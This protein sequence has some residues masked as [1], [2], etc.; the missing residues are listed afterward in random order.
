M[1]CDELTQRIAD[2]LTGDLDER[3]LTALGEHLATCPGCAAEAAALEALWHGLDDA[4]PVPSARLRPRFE[5][6]LERASENADRAIGVGEPRRHLPAW[7]SW[8]SGA[9]LALAAAI[10]AVAL[11]LGVYVGARAASRRDAGD[12]AALR[13]EVRSLRTTVALALLAEPS[14]SGRLSGVA[15]GR[16]L[17]VADGRVADALYARFLD[18]P[19]VN[20][21]LAALDALRWRAVLPE[22]RARLLEAIPAQDS[23]LVQLS[24]IDVLFESQA[25]GS[26]EDVERLAND[27]GLDV[28]VA[29]YVRDRLERGP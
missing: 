3:S 19:N 1:R 26:R 21:R 12:V 9:V 20:V 17:Q 7:R 5:W 15:Y 22:L 16:E 13:E 2:R 24:A 14:A 4:A 8:R 11:G 27:P 25:A 10:A 6:M 29:G 18:D 28:V 23:P